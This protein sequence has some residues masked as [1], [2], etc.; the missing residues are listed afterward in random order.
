[1]W[2]KFCRVSVGVG[3]IKHMNERGAVVVAEAVATVAVHE[4]STAVVDALL[5]QDPVD[6]PGAVALERV[7][8]M[9]A[10]VGR[11]QVAVLAGIVDVDRRQLFALDTAGGDPV[12][13]ASPSRWGGRSAG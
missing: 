2:T 13:V 3:I 7:R 9:L 6:I 8:S 12:V 5:A 10:D 4:L 1:M 11:V